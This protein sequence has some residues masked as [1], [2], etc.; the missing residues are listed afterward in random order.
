V[1]SLQPR[2][3]HRLLRCPLCKTGF[4]AAAGA[5]VCR[6]GHSFDLARG[7]YVNLLRPGRRRP[8][9][10]GDSPVQL[11]HRAAF[12]D[13]GHLDAV[14]ATIVEHI[15]TADAERAPSTWRILDAGSGTG[16]HLARV[17]NALTSPLIGLGLDISKD[18][19]R[20]AARR[21]PA[22]AFAATDLWG[23]WPVHDG[24][25][26]LVLSIF[27]PKNFPEA[28]RVL[29]PGGWL[30]VAYPGRDHLVE[31][32]RRFGLLRQYGDNAN[33]YPDLMAHFIGPSITTRLYNRVLLDDAML[34]SVVLMGPNAHHVD[35]PVLNAGSGSPVVTL[36]INVLFARKS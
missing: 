15:V 34:R 2:P 30:A 1:P 9:A 17:T 3:G 7:G 26:D 5:L 25:A 21:W 23:V 31:V 24:V 10:A 35:P 27:A 20:R 33:R 11:G 36:D 19:A 12:L 16:H 18:A 13:A 29:C 14:A 22:L 28:A 6:N 8:A 32:R 4:I